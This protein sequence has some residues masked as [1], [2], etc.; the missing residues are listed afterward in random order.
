[1]S[2]FSLTGEQRKLLREIFDWLK[3]GSTD[4]LTVGGYAG[5]GKTTVIGIFRLMVGK[6]WPKTKVAFC[7]YTGKA[8]RVLAAA[9]RNAGADFKGDGVSTI[10]GLIYSAITDSHDRIIG[11]NRK[12]KLKADLI[13]V[14][15]ASMVTFEI[16]QDL[17]DY[18]IPIL[19][20]G[21][22]GQLPPIG[23]KFNL[24][25]Q[26]QLKLET[27]HRQAAGNP[28][29]KL[30]MMAREN[31]SIPV[32]TYGAGVRKL[33]RYEGETGQEVEA[34]LQERRTDWLVLTGY[35]RTRTEINRQIRQYRECAEDKPQ[36]GDRVI[37]LK[38]NWE[39]GI[40]NGMTG[41]I[42][43]LI[44]ITDQGEIRWYD[45]EILMDDDN[46]LYTGRINARQFG[47]PA[48]L[49]EDQ[50]LKGQT[51]GDLFDFGYALTVHKAQGS[52]AP[53]VLLFE[54]RNSHMTDDDWRRWLYTGVTR[55][56]ETLTIVGTE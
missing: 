56:E 8:S 55:A 3:S 11:W 21:D 54:E 12:E 53:K 47:Q 44:P 4:S 18:G 20:V 46:F 41:K 33:N 40:Y 50:G 28:I 9:L 37:A 17:L 15:E 32:G 49:S 19:A 52:Q 42:G 24:M 34:I 14:D 7:A 26:P 38:N 29:I 13:V 36:A 25:A 35:N 51:M 1:M 23:G 43:R 5:T 2:S 27:I 22:H 31:G 39:H 10:H 45:A 30:S 48:T 16:W 6:G